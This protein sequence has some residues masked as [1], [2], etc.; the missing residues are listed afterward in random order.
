M[1]HSERGGNSHSDI[2]NESN[3]AVND[4][5]VGIVD[6]IVVVVFVV[7]VVISIRNF[8][9]VI[10]IILVAF[11]NVDFILTKGFK[12]VLVNL[13]LFNKNKPFLLI[14]FVIIDKIEILNRL[15]AW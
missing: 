4:D 13:F 15:V 3:A 2:V 11:F 1:N 10:V 7:D 12:F 14:V 9:V 5:D 8:F 6:V